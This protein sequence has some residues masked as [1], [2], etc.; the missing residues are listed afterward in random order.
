MGRLSQ[1]DI[2]REAKMQEEKPHV[3]EVEDGVKDPDQA[4]TEGFMRIG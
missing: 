3:E 2:G 1:P 4:E